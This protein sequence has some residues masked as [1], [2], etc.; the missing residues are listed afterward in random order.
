MSTLVSL[1]H[2]RWS[3]AI[4]AELHRQRGSRFVTLANR[5]GLSRESLR[6][7]LASL[8]ASGLVERNPGYGHPLRPEYRLTPIGAIV[9][10]RCAD[11]LS[12]LE[13]LGAEEIGLKKWSLPVLRALDEQDRPARFSELRA[14]LPGVTSRALA[15]T[16]KD[17]SAAGLVDREVTG[18]FPPATRYHAT[19]RALPLLRVLRAF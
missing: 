3:P 1:L 19:P 18:D 11:L 9:A 14:G 17:L 4:L 13:T 6:R 2:H 8:L 5:V 10:P 12:A 7:T 16:L 15:L